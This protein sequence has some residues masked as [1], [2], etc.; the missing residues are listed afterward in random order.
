[1][2]RSEQVHIQLGYG[3]SQAQCARNLGISRQRVSQ[4][5]SCH[6][7][8]ERRKRGRKPKPLPDGAGAFYARLASA[9]EAGPEACGIITRPWR[10]AWSIKGIRELLLTFGIHCSAERAKTIMQHIGWE[11]GWG[12]A[13]MDF[14]IR[15]FFPRDRILVVPHKT[16]GGGWRP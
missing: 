4:L 5:A 14:L 15:A 9:V 13:P 6:V 16:V 3:V 8:R 12:R 2:T 7:V 10:D 11:W 1:M